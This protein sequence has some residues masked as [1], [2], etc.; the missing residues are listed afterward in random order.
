MYFP[1]AIASFASAIRVLT[2]YQDSPG[3][4]HIFWLSPAMIFSFVTRRRVTL[5]W[6][7]HKIYIN[8]DQRRD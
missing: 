5:V 4:P 7:T 8:S 1:C 6:N 3:K 2:G